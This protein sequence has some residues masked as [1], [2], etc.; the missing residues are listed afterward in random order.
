[1]KAA[2]LA[3]GTELLGPDRVDTNSLRLAAVLARHGVELRRKVILGDSVA[4]IAD[5][6]RRMAADFSLIL[7]SGGLGP[8]ADDVTREAVARALGR[9]R[10]LDEAIVADIEA[11][12]ARWGRQMPQV[13][14]RQGE[15]LDG[16]TLIPNPRGTAPGMILTEQG[17][18][19]QGATLFLLPGVPRELDGMVES[20]LLPWLAEHASGDARET[21]VL[22]VA[23]V[24]ESELEERIAPAYQEFDRESIT[25]L[26]K[27]ADITV[28]ATAGGAPEERRQLLDRMVERLAALIGDAIYAFEDTSLE[29]V[30]GRLLTEAGATVS[31]AESCTG[32]LIAERLTR[33]AGSSAYFVGAAVTY[34]NAMK[35]QLLGVSADDL[36]THGA[37][38]EPVARAMA[39]GARERLGTD[40]ALAVTGVAGPGGGSE[41]KPVGTVHLAVA[42]PDGVH[43]RRVLLPG[44]R[45]RIRWQ[46]SQVA[47]EMLRRTLRLPPRPA[48]RERVEGERRGEGT[49]V[50]TGA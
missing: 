33:T 12:F 50:P 27:P 41:E 16:A 32:G 20:H 23:C 37:V 47:L 39:T 48:P 42:G 34:S 19:R 13:N 28:R 3:I 38:S 40:Y 18:S 25:V 46:T 45:E 31:T 35:Q 5:E 8:T 11:K 15:V 4:E 21:R 26:A 36:K 43:H 29:A 14:R 10:T 44:D 2:F 24:P 9:E 6:V 49:K 30:V 17:L 22:K 7:I 1:M